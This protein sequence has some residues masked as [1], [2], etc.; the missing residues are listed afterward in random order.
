MT[1]K[2]IISDVQKAKL[3]GCKVHKGK[4]VTTMSE[5][6][7]DDLLKILAEKFDLL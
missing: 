3:A 6:D 2:R 5:A 4:D 1:V 7:K